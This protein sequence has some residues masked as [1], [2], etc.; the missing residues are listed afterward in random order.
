MNSFVN[1]ISSKISERRSSLRKVAR[2]VGLDPSFLSKVLAGKRSPPSDEKILK[3]LAKFLEIDPTLLIISTGKIPSELQPLM[4]D[5]LFLKSLSKSGME[6]SA[7]PPSHKEKS[8]EK[9]KTPRMGG[10][11]PQIKDK[12]AGKEIFKPL[13]KEKAQEEFIQKSKILSEDLL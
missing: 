8:D 6:S 4:E 2:G 13:K 10:L 7:V 3:R 11:S 9:K 5:P 12:E 1:L